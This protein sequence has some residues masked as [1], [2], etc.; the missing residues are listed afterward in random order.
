MK[1]KDNLSEVKNAKSQ[2]AA[3]NIVLCFFCVVRGIL[4]YTYGYFLSNSGDIAFPI[5]PLTLFMGI[6]TLAVFA[7]LF[8]VCM[9]TKGKANSI[10]RAIIFGISAAFYIQGNFLAVNMG[11]LNGSEYDVPA[12]KS[13]L[14]IAIWLVIMAIPFFILIKFPNIFDNTVS[15]TSA[16]IIL[17]QIFTL[18]ISPFLNMSKYGTE[19]IVEFFWVIPAG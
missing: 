15:Y 8:I 5:K 19:N 4:F 14:N 11:L 13:A 3:A 7:V 18:F 9:L 17:I 2:K 12:W 1:A 16:A 6:V 10:F